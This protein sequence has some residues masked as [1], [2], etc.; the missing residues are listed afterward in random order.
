MNK[1]THQNKREKAP[2]ERAQHEE[3]KTYR[4]WRR[5]KN[6]GAKGQAK[7]EGRRRRRGKTKNKEYQIQK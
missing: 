3:T 2:T 6:K 5:G 4:D 7:T 1:K